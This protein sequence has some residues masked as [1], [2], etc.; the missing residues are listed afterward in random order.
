MNN[1]NNKEYL[2]ICFEKTLIILD[3]SIA[4]I[5]FLQQILFA[6]PDIKLC[7]LQ[8]TKALLIEAFEIKNQEIEA[9]ERFI[10]EIKRF[11]S[12]CCITSENKIKQVW[13]II[14]PVI[15]GYL[16]KKSYLKCKKY[17]IE[18]YITDIE[19][20]IHPETIDES[21]YIELEVLETGSSFSSILIYYIKLEELCVIKKPTSKDFEIQ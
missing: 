12:I 15:S 19:K 8:D 10:E 7:F 18:K 17:R 3:H 20:K 1:R 4:S 9:D 11:A 13:S 16:I 21:E 2:I 14:S 6:N 5:S